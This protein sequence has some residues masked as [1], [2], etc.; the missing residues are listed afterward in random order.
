MILSVTRKRGYL[1]FLGIY[2]L[3]IPNATL[4]LIGLTTLVSQI[5]GGIFEIPSGMV[6]DW[7][8]HKNAIVLAYIVTA[9]STLV[10]M[11]A[12][13]PVFFFLAGIL[14]TLAIALLSGTET[15]FLHNTLE[16]IGRSRDFSKISGRIKSVGTLFSII[17]VIGLPLLT[18]FSF[19]WVFLV[20]LIIDVVGIAT[21]YGLTD[22]CLE[23]KMVAIKETFSETLCSWRKTQWA[24]YIIIFSLGFG[25]STGAMFG[26]KD[27]YQESLGFTIPFLGLLWATSRLF[28]TGLGAI[29]GWIY[30][31]TTFRSIILIQIFVYTMSFVGVYFFSNKWIVATLFILC[32]N[33]RWGLRS[34]INHHEMNFIKNRPNGATLLSINGFIVNIILGA[35]GVLMGYLI[36]RGGYSQAYLFIGSVLGVI[37]VCGAWVM[38]RRTPYEIAGMDK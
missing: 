23:K 16:S 27:V 37:F 17:L 21:A 18:H 4:N 22:P 5:A 31:V 1:S 11:I 33:A 30:R 7:I 38:P 28:E 13:H 35:T 19:R 10:Y 15:T 14:Y 25:I 6:S 34:V 12:V 29:N 8:G 2:M 3:S 20:M 26:F 32:L 36:V 24:P 9:L